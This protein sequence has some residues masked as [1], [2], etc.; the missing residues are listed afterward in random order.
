MKKVWVI[1]H[2]GTA[3]HA[4]QNTN[5]A[6]QT[7]YRMKADG[8][9]TDLQLTADNVLVVNHNYFIDDNSNGSGAGCDMAYD[10]LVKYDYGAYKDEKFAGEKILTID[11]LLDIVKDF[12]I[13]NLEL[14]SALHKDEPFAKTVVDAVDRK[15][16]T[17][18]VIFS[19]FDVNLIR[20][21]KGY[22]KQYKVGYLPMPEGYMSQMR[23][24]AASMFSM[25]PVDSAYVD[26]IMKDV[27][28]QKT[29]RELMS[30]LD[31]EI[32]YW[33]PH[34]STALQ[35]PDLIKELSEKGIGCNPWTVDDAEVMKKCIEMGCTG[36]ISNLPDLTYKVVNGEV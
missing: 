29:M 27:N 23:E 10:E 2:R 12:E 6:F 1:G 13:I 31:F 30:E 35:Y 28:T 32:D 24:R 16:L 25:Y 34:Y 7:A 18:K 22:G 11:E 5:A 33:H 8:I 19:S 4:P 15:G 20:E 26:K 3:A 36:I 21:I 14:K 9:E 17:D